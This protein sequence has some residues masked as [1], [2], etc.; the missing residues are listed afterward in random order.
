MQLIAIGE[1][2]KNLDKITSGKLL[3][4]YPE[5]EWKKAKAMRDIISH[6]YFDLDAEMVYD[7]CQR[8]IPNMKRIIERMIKDL[9][10]K[11]FMNSHL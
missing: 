2:L 7:V 6:H 3:A 11:T 10:T 1:S 8:H 5:I 4:K 9:H